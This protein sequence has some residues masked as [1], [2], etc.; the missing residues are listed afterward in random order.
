MPLVEWTEADAAMETGK[1]DVYGGLSPG[2]GRAGKHS[3]EEGSASRA[4]RTLEELW[5]LEAVCR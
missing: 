3:R 4:E 1:Q 2:G 5:Q